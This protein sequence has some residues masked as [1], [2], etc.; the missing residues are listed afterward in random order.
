MTTTNF[1]V[2]KI[3]CGACEKLIKISLGKLPGVKKSSVNTSSKT[4]T[5]EFDETLVSK[6]KIQQQAQNAL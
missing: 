5:V 2:P 3:N 6:E 1:S 4:V